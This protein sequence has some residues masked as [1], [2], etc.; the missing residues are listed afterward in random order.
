[1]NRKPQEEVTLFIR[2]ILNL[3]LEWCF[4]CV[5]GTGSLLPTWWFHLWFR[6]S[7]W[8][9]RHGWGEIPTYNTHQNECNFKKYDYLFILKMLNC[10]QIYR[11]SNTAA[12]SYFLQWHSLR[13]VIPVLVL[14]YFTKA[15]LKKKCF[16]TVLP[17]LLLPTGFLHNR[18]CCQT[19]WLEERWA[20]Q[21]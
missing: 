3:S 9:S 6:L 8:E 21:N 16:G 14:I 11:I 4:V 19:C 13:C 10:S 15:T 5:C 20:R 17:Y 7:S 12:Q 18:A 1:M 2:Q